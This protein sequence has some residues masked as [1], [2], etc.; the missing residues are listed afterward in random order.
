M[1]DQVEEADH[2]RAIERWLAS[3]VRG[4]PFAHEPAVDALARAQFA[5][6]KFTDAFGESTG[7]A[8][9]HDGAA[10]YDDTIARAAA[11]VGADA[12]GLAR[13]YLERGQFF[14]ENV[15]G[16][17]RLD[18]E[19]AIALFEITGDRDGIATACRRLA[20]ND[21]RRA[22]PETEGWLRRAIAT[23]PDALARQR[24]AEALAEHLELGASPAQH[25]EA[26]AIRAHSVTLCL[27]VDPASVMAARAELLKLQLAVR[28]LAGA[29]E[30]AA[31]MIGAVESSTD[32]DRWRAIEATWALGAA[33]DARAI[34]LLATA[35]TVP[36]C[37]RE[38]ER[39]VVAPYNR[40]DAWVGRLRAWIGARLVE[41][42]G[43]PSAIEH[44]LCDQP[45]VTE[46]YLVAADELGA[47]GDPR[48]ELIV[49]QH[50]RRAAPDDATLRAREVELLETH[51]LALLGLVE[52]RHAHWHLGY[53]REVA[54]ATSDVGMLDELFAHRSL[55]L[56]Q[57]LR[58][59]VTPS[60][61][62]GLVAH[63]EALRRIP[64][65]G[66]AGLEPDQVARLRD[67]VPQVIAIA[68]AV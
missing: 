3:L 48:G 52:P 35:W 37:A 51:R 50:R 25:A 40:G 24:D 26:L 29:R 65:V 18:F 28:D 38:I 6:P 32:A 36:V 58:L 27:A 46:H 8:W 14:D 43:P 62:P 67:L 56:V 47:R 64:D 1:T 2:R 41:L 7:P 12:P 61:L 34:E 17:P 4:E 22:M 30:V 63:A 44:Q 9:I 54:F 57:S 15:H 49:V 55:L 19:R 39:R 10:L 23:R 20:A 13:M 66:I 33:G 5:I 16:S 68:K 11:I 53:L 60:L 59:G 42:A 31:A 21:W 45:D